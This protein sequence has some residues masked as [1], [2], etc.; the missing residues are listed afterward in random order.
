M[1]ECKLSVLWKLLYSVAQVCTCVNKHALLVLTLPLQPSHTLKHSLAHPRPRTGECGPSGTC[2]PCCIGI[3]Y[4]GTD[5]DVKIRVREVFWQH[6]TW[7]QENRRC[8]RVTES[9]KY[10]ISRNPLLHISGWPSLRQWWAYSW[11]KQM[12]WGIRGK[13]RSFIVRFPISFHSRFTSQ[14]I[15]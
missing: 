2:F 5:G 7:S 4:L 12:Q 3:Y 8:K 14:E 9:W 11:P 6:D 13:D 10:G 15:I 1:S